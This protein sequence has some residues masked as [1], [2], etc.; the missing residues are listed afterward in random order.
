MT[1]RRQLYT[2]AFIK[3]GNDVLL[4]LKTRGLGKGLW[5]GFG[6]KVEPNESIREAAE[7]EIKEEC[8]LEVCDLNHIGFM[9][10]EEDDCA[11]ISIVHIFT[12]TQFRGKPEGSEEMNPVQWYQREDLQFLKMY[13]DFK[14][15]EGYMFEDKF[16]CGLVRYNKQRQIVE[17]FIKEC[18]SLNEVFDCL[19]Q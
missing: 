8:C 2:L 16:F 1:A 6:G 18:N 14:E 13:H 11:E 3:R 9:R 10:Y 12:G 7:R 17:K 19:E 5:N 4:G 15:W